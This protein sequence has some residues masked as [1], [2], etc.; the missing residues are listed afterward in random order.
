MIF[1]IHEDDVGILWIG[2]LGGITRYDG[3]NFIAIT[4][5]NGLPANSAFQILE[6]KNDNFWITCSDGV[7]TISKNDLNLFV[8]KKN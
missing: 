3:K 4:D 8:K 7:Y 2:T 6:D 5:K 1:Q